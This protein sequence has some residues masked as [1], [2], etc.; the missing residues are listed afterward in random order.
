M[1]QKDINNLI[2]LAQEKIRNGVSKEEALK[3][4]MGAGI[5]NEKAQFT[6]PYAN[7]ESIFTKK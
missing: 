7:L 4:F 2:E 6:Q 5:L 1:S 3:T